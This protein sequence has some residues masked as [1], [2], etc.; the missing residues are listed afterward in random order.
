MRF[1]LSV[2]YITEL[3]KS[4]CDK[5]YVD[6]FE[7]RGGFS[8][9]V[10]LSDTSKVE[11]FFSEEKLEDFEV[12]LGEDNYTAYGCRFR[13]FID[14]E[15][16]IGLG[17]VSLIPNFKVSKAFLEEKRDW[18]KDQCSPVSLDERIAQI[19]YAGLKKVEV[20]LSGI[21][22]KNPTQADRLI[23]IQDD[24]RRVTGI[25]DYYHSHGQSLDERS[26][27]VKSLSLL[28]AAALSEIIEREQGRVEK[29]RVVVKVI[30]QEIYGIVRLLRSSAFLEIPLP[31]WMKDY[32]GF[33]DQVKAGEIIVE[34][35]ESVVAFHEMP[36]SLFL[37]STC[38][39]LI[40]LREG[41]ARFL[42]GNGIVVI[43]SEDPRFHDGVQNHPHDICLRKVDEIPSFL[44]VI[45]REAGSE[46]GGVCAEYQGLTVT[47]AETMR[48]RQDQSKKL[49]CF[50]RHD[51]WLCYD[52]WVQ[53]GRRDNF[54]YK[55]LDNRVFALLDYVTGQDIWWNTFLHLEDLKAKVAARLRI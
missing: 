44:V 37:S 22:E 52:V 33:S 29:P 5:C 28:K 34:L 8:F 20:F 27:S 3:I 42:E 30:D 14:F 10:R 23:E 48:A 13:N 1:Q 35:K 32:V 18:W 50:V 53:N 26:A 36:P 39:D 40:D 17:E 11:I 38:T 19:F 6:V 49:H 9:R 4:L 45:D 43:R 21:L 47:H 24:L 41:L 12:V 7:D 15:I 25:I 2:D 16:Y 55:G 46:Y 31:E 51:V 54:K